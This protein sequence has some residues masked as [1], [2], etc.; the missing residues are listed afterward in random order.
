VAPVA[1]LWVIRCRR[2]WVDHHEGVGRGGR[3]WWRGDGDDGLLL[4][5][6]HASETS[7]FWS[8]SGGELDAEVQGWSE[9]LWND[10]RREELSAL[11]R[12]DESIGG[13]V[14]I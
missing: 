4:D 9:R 1:K 10:G 5:L 14:G 11:Q 7:M 8:E 13:H 3:C 2:V 6:A 12:V